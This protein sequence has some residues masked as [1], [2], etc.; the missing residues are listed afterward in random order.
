[1]AL[2]IGWHGE[3]FAR[4][5]RLEHLSHYQK[6]VASG[7]RDPDAG[8]FELRAMIGRMKTRQEAR[9]GSK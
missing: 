2:S 3:A 8:A 1:M 5:K 4:T 6:Q 9:R 7:A